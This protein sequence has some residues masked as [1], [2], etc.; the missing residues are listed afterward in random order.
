MRSMAVAAIGAWLAL[1]AVQGQASWT[2]QTVIP[3]VLAIRTPTTHI[4]FALTLESYPPERFPARY[5][6]T[7]PEGGVLPVQV[8]SNAEGI[9]SLYLEVPD[10]VTEDGRTIPARQVLFR[11]NGGTWTRASNVPQEFYTDRGPTNGWKEIRLEFA[12][13]LLGNEPPGHYQVD[14]AIS[15]IRE[16]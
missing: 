7:D 5:P 6:A 10:M 2:A 8:F 16:P 14:V 9:W 3:G 1:A 4:A 15:G 12:L 11:T 13:E